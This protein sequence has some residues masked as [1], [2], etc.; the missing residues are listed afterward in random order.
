MADKYPNISPYAYCAWNPVK[1][2]D[3]NGRDIWELTNDGKLNW[4]KVSKTETIK[5]G[6]KSIFSR[7]AIF[8]I[9]NKEGT[10]INLKDADMS[11]GTNQELAEMYFEFFADNLGYE[12]SLLGFEN[13]NEITEFEITTSLNKTGDSKG[14]QRALNLSV[15]NK[16]KIHVHNHPDNIITPSSPNNKTGAGDDLTFWGEVSKSSSDCRFYIYTREKG[17]CY[18][19]YDA[20]GNASAAVPS[21]YHKPQYGRKQN[22]NGFLASSPL[23]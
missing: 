18:V 6:R 12:F 15:D 16:L 21:A 22:E 7:N 14:S 4:V 11:F 13:S 19:P 3:P 5:M 9:N 17:G 1:L 2:V 8:G 23:K 20:K 10:T